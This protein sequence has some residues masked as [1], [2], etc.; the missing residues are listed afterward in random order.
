MWANRTFH[1]LL[2]NKGD[3]FSN[4]FKKRLYCFP[5]LETVA[6]TFHQIYNAWSLAGNPVSNKVNLIIRKYDLNRQQSHVLQEKV[7]GDVARS[8]KAV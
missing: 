7:P 8:F 3:M 2:L 6:C 1:F 5:N 4:L